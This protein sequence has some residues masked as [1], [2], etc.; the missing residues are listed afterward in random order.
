MDP[1]ELRLKN[2]SVEGDIR[3][4]GEKWERIGL[5]ECLERAQTAES[6]AV[7]CSFCAG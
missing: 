3:A 2:A 1:L 5:A 7:K 4:D 6:S